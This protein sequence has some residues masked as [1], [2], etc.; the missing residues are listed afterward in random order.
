[1]TPWSATS[2]SSDRPRPGHRQVEH[3]AADA[4]AVRRILELRDRI[5]PHQ[6]RRDRQHQRGFVLAAMDVRQACRRAAFHPDRGMQHADIEREV[7]AQILR[8]RFQDAAIA[9]MAVDDGEVARRQAARDR[10]SEVAQQ[11]AHAGKR[12]R[13]RAGRPFVLAREADGERRQL[14]TIVGLAEARDDAAGVFLGQ[15][16]VGVE[17]QMRAVLL[18]RADRQAED[19]AFAQQLADFRRRKLCR[20]SGSALSSAWPLANLQAARQ[21]RGAA[22]IAAFGHVAT[23]ERRLGRIGER[24]HQMIEPVSGARRLRR[25]IAARCRN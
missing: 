15:H 7:G 3:R 11:R 1:M 23:G 14:P 22:T 8:Q 12:Q 2:L 5:A 10:A 4:I 19:R 21:Q 16:G 6:L 13:Q 24:G 25:Q 9:A 18:D 17:R 20:S